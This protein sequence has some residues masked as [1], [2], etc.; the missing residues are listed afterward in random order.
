MRIISKIKILLPSYSLPLYIDQKL[1][2]NIFKSSRI[3]NV[4]C[5]CRPFLI[6]PFCVK[7]I[8]ILGLIQ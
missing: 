8:R 6:P 5:L 2:S 4:L 3:W 7:L 1:G